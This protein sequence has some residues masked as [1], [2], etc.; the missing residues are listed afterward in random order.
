MGVVAPG[1]EKKKNELSTV[2]ETSGIADARG[3]KS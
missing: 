2:K 3:F 1:K